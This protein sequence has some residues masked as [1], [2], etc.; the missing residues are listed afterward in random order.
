MKKVEIE[1]K[2]FF[3][4]EDGSIRIPHEEMQLCLDLKD[5]ALLY[6][7]SKKALIERELDREDITFPVN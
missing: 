6:Q 5:I 2:N 4:Y 1:G 7:E 3:V